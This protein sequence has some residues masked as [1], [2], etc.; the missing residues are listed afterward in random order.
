MITRER[1]TACDRALVVPDADDRQLHLHAEGEDEDP[2]HD[3][4]KAVQDVEPETDLLSHPHRREL[5]DVDRSE[6]A[7]RQRDRRRDGDEHQRSDDRRCDP[8]ALLT[9][10]RR[11]LREEVEVDRSDAATS[12]RPDDKREQ[13]DREHGGEHRPTFRDTIEEQAAPSAAGRLQA[14][15]RLVHQPPPV[16][17]NSKRLT[18]RCAATF[19]MNVITSRISAR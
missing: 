9:E 10:E 19:V 11:S 16:R 8:A 18:T 14:D 1:E 4:R 12:D 3:R 15:R 13:Q 6:D 7:E 17:W 2:D 5:A